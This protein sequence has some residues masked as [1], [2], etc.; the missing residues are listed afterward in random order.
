MDQL[1]SAQLSEWEAYDKLDPIG[2][3]RDD[4]RMAYL[5]SMITNLVISI[6]GKKGAKHTVP[7]DYMPKWDAEK[8]SIVRKQTPEE[9]KELLLDLAKMHNKNVGRI[10]NTKSP[11]RIQ[12]TKTKGI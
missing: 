7:L 2:T 9:M 11:V 10:D 4:Y 5:A 8:E 1:T 12:P 6:H 3:W